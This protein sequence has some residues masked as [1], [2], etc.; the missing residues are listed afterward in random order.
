ML[1]AGGLR[2]QLGGLRAE[3][4]RIQQDGLRAEGLRDLLGGLTWVLLTGAGRS[5]KLLVGRGIR[6]RCSHGLFRGSLGPDSHQILRL[7][8]A[9]LC[10]RPETSQVGCQSWLLVQLPQNVPALLHAGGHGLCPIL[11]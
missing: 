10:P 8:Q 4:L 7:N 2:I 5:K 11:S 6:N 3:G 9:V 1:R